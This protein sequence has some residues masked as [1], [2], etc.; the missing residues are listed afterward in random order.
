MIPR[1]IASPEALAAVAAAKY[2]DMLKCAYFDISRGTLANWCVQ[3]GAKVN[4][5]VNAMKQHLLSE[6]LVCADETTVQ[7]LDEPI[8]Q[9]Q[10]NRICGLS[11]W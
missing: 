5:L 1:S 6:S 3:L 9:R 11:Y 10:A 8:E 4:V 7:V 2:I